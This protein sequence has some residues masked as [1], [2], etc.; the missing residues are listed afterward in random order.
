MQCVVVRNVVEVSGCVCC[1][2]WLGLGEL[3]VE[4]GQFL[5]G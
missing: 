2:W 3:R 5:F 1:W 4:L